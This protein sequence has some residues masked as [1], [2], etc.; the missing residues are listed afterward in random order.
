M[1][2]TL[3]KMVGLATMVLAIFAVLFGAQ[4]PRALGLGGIVW[5]VLVAVGVL[6]FIVGFVLYVAIRKN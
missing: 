6:G 4:L 1:N 3:I 2:E 5:T